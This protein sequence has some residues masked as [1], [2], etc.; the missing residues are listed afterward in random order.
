MS[1][2]IEQNKEDN[3]ENENKNDYQKK[4]SKNNQRYSQTEP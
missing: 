3:V 1:D 2:T 4:S